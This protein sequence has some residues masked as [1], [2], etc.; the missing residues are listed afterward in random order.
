[1]ELKAYQQNV[2]NDLSAYIDAVDSTN[3]LNAGWEK[4]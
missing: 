1:M 4:W 3:D 2:M